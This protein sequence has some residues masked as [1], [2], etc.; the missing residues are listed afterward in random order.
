MGTKLLNEMAKGI[1]RYRDVVRNNTLGAFGE[2]L[3]FRIAAD[4][5]LQTDRTNGHLVAHWDLEWRRLLEKGLAPELDVSVKFKKSNR[6]EVALKELDRVRQ[7]GIDVRYA[8]WARRIVNKDFGVKIPR[9]VSPDTT[10]F[11]LEVEDIIRAVL[12]PDHRP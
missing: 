3:K 6:V 4:A 2:Y 12:D 9:P 7:D 1:D 11:W 10:P 8:D 5:G